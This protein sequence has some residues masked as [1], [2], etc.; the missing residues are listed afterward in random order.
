M[1]RVATAMPLSTP[2]SRMSKTSTNKWKVASLFAGCGGSDLGM[3]GDFKFLDEY[4]GP[5]NVQIV[6]AND[7]DGPACETY[8]LNFSHKIHHADITQV[9]TSDIPDH[10]ILVGGFPCQAFSIVGQRKSLK[11]P[12][13]QLFYEMIRILK[14]KKPAAFIAEN[15]K[16]LMNVDKGETFK[17]ILKEFRKAGY[18]VTY[19][20][21]NAADY[22]V[23][24]KR[25][26]V[27]IVGVNKELEKPFEFPASSHAEVPTRS[28]QKWI[29]LGAVIDSLKPKNPKYVFSER[30]HEGLLRANKAFNKGRAQD[31]TRP[32]NT[33]STHLAKVSLNGT[34]PVLY[35]SRTK[36]YRRF[37][38]REA[39]RIQ[40]FPDNFKFAGNDGNAYRQIG[41][42][43][44]PVMMWRVFGSVLDTLGDRPTS[45]TV[46][47]AEPALAVTE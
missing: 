1:A 26:R 31:L 47:Y 43:I 23:P 16:G 37:T 28:Q 13:G 7:F 33:I 41:N 15:V 22:G 34:D 17:L 24:Q 36:K 29:P 45:P 2:T 27:F 9:K 14:D 30:A 35:N 32:C 12:R 25:E 3:L 18:D 21:L 8:N 38:P 42:A 20:L 19:Q 5:H 46:S 40:S 4:F 44:A 11:D 6:Y 39:A 10:D